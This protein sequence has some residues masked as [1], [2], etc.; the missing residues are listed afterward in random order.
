MKLSEIAR[1]WAA[2]ELTRI[3]KDGDHVT[4]RAPFACPG[5][6]LRIAGERGAAPRLTTHGEPGEC[7]GAP[8][9]RLP[10][11]L[12]EAADPWTLQPGTWMRDREGTVVCFDLPK[13]QSILQV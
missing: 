8:P 12:R 1:Y 4:L 13:G 7:V 10:V 2:K 6:T 5:F 9:G 11:A 3:K